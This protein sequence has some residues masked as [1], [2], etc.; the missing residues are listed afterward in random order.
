[1]P[2][3]LKTVAIAMTC[4][5]IAHA[6]QA[7]QQPGL[8]ESLGKLLQPQKQAMT[9]EASV[10]DR[11]L[12]VT[13]KEHRVALVIGNAAYT[14][15]ALVNPVNDARAMARRLRS[16]GF[17][18]VLRE[19]LKARDI[20]GVYREFR[21]KVTPGGVALVFYAGHGIQFKGQNYFPA[22]DAD[23]HSEEDVP[24][25]S[26]NLGNLLDNMEEAKAGVSLVFLD[27]C[28]DNPF[29]RRFRS[30][31]RGLAKVEAAS[32]ML[33]HYATRP[34]SIASD[35]EGQNGTYTEALLA[36]MSAPGVPVELMLKR[37]ANQVVAK[38]KGKQE[39]WVEGSLRGDF[40]FIFQ[41]PATV[42]VQA[43][44]ADP[45]AETWA[46][47]EDAKTAEGYQA[48]L[49]AWP[50]GRYAVAAR[51]KL[52]GLQKPAGSAAVSPAPTFA[53]VAVSSA[54]ENPETAMWNEVKAS[55]VREY[56]DAYLKQ[57]PKGKYVALAKI[58]LKKLDERDKA[59]RAKETSEKQQAAERERQ[60]ALR[61]EQ[62]AWDGAKTTGTSAAYASYLERYPKGRYAALAQ[63]ALPKLQ[64]EAAERAKLDAERQRAETERQRL[65]SERD[66][67]E[68]ERHRIEAE[69]KGPVS[70]RER[71]AAFNAIGE[72]RPGKVFKDCADC[73]EMVVIPPGTFEMGANWYDNEKPAHTV[74]LDKAFALGRTEVT[75]EQWRMIMGSNPSHFSNCGDNCPV[76]QVSW[77]DVN[78]F[79]QRLNAKTGNAYRLPSEAEWE[80]ACRAGGSLA[81]CGGASIESEAWYVSNSGGTTHSVAG[82]HGNAWG[83]YD[84]SGNVWEWTGDCW[85]D[86]YIDA[87]ADGS[88]WNRGNCNERVLRG[89][90]WKSQPQNTRSTKRDGND[91]NYRGSGTGFRLVRALP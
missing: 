48:Y 25:Q 47:A 89:G 22:I 88:A 67:Q 11:T 90:S 75:Q 16:L 52:R 15:G 21:S 28:R 56:L 31:T 77:E 69:R 62:A 63:A 49:D 60:E 85:N 76:E 83:I 30:G 87:P 26:L 55:G 6:Q 71:L 9:D 73:P 39:P 54:S 80:Y 68:E 82:K 36:Q 43:P 23:I 78:I 86:S 72:L 24:L 37:V 84:M 32:G 34:G 4:V 51:I 18:V 35:G 53:P 64:R 5:S 1:M 41:G 74:R 46:A 42:Q 7:P 19:N 2:A 10:P 70:E 50:Q 45:E 13:G 79:I 38:T 81:Q 61:V 27:A 8:L 20:G 14:Q 17:D 91:T 33:I 44:A 12:A 59:Q 66:K 29:A 58:E 3:L 65:I 57:Y 40:Y